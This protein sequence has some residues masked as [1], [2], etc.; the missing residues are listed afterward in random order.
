MGA[1]FTVMTIIGLGW[2]YNAKR[3]T[4]SVLNCF[5]ITMNYLK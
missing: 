4:I 1:C 5:L 3:F 2:A